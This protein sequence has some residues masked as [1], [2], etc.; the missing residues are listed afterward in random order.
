[1]IKNAKLDTENLRSKGVAEIKR[2]ADDF[3]KNSSIELENLKAPRK[4]VY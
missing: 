3:A 4:N 1:L 2:A